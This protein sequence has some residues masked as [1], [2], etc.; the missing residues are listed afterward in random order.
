MNISKYVSSPGLRLPPFTAPSPILDRDVTV[1]GWL[2]GRRQVRGRQASSFKAEGFGGGQ[3]R[4]ASPY[5]KRLGALSRS[6]ES[7][8]CSLLEASEPEAAIAHSVFSSTCNSY[9]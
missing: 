2:G 7:P 5:I 8:L 3:L 9:L 1:G 4:C 6:L